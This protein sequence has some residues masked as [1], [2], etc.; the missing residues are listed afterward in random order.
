MLRNPHQIPKTEQGRLWQPRTTGWQASF[1]AQ[2]RCG[3]GVLPTV[4]SV[5]LAV[6]CDDRATSKP[7]TGPPCFLLERFR[8]SCDWAGAARRCDAL[9]NVHLESTCQGYDNAFSFLFFVIWV[10]ATTC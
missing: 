6:I 1:L 5:S 8:L 7:R 3:Q 4:R 10:A 9:R 2:R